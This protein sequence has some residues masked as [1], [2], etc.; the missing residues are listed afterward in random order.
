MKPQK[1]YPNDFPFER[2]RRVTPEEVEAAR[3]AIE[4]MTGKPRPPRGR[5]PKP[6]DE[7]Y[8]AVSIRLHPQVLA[9]AKKEGKKRGLGYQSVINET[10]LKAAVR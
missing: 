10:L 5:P 9:W 1:K 4:R 7:R 6:E 8:K 2:A 3:R